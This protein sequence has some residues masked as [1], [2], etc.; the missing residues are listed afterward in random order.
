[1]QDRP[2]VIYD[3]AESPVLG[4]KGQAMPAVIRVSATFGEACDLAC[5]HLLAELGQRKSEAFGDY[6]RL[7]LYNAI[8][9][10]NRLHG[11]TI[12][13]RRARRG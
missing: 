13:S 11:S 3:Q 8:P 7:D 2:A 10:L 5:L 1:L 9:D 4:E 6:G 12:A